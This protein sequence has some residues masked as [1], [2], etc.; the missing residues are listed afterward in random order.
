[1]SVGTYNVA[2]GRHPN[3][4]GDQAI[5]CQSL[6]CSADHKDDR[7]CQW[8]ANGESSGNR[9]GECRKQ[10][11]L[12]AYPIDRHPTFAETGELTAV[13]GTRAVTDSAPTAFQKGASE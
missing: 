11:Y 12:R 2:T 6:P 5:E 10:I 1:M 7:E 3:G 13:T 4:S 9:H 8:Q